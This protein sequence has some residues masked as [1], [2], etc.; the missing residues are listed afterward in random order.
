MKKKYFT[1]LL[2]FIVPTVICSAIMWPAAAM[3]FSLIGG[4]A[5]MII[6][7]VVTYITGI[8]LVLKDKN[9]P[10]QQVEK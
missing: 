4:F 6:S 7:M 3:K 2:F 8:N 1:P 10:N 5:V 9:Q